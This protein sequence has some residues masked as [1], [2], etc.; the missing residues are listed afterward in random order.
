MLERHHTGGPCPQTEPSGPDLD[1]VVADA[2]AVGLAYV[3]IGGFSVIA[4]GYVRA[5]K[6][7]TCWC[8]TAPMPT[9]PSCVSWSA[10]KAD[11][12]RDGKVLAAEDV[13]GAHHLR[14]GVATASSTSCAA[15]CR[16]SITRP[17][18]PPNR[19]R[20]RWGAGPLRRA[21][22]A[23]SAS[24]AWPA[25]RRTARDLEDSKASKRQLPIDPIPG[26]DE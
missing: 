4:N 13:A 1:G 15:V 22:A 11:A 21:F 25:G 2:N 20:S 26:L 9:R 3:V 18:R 5:T 19:G 10:S 23:S 14:C 17:W 24:S 6:T 8:P 16:R 12:L 7:P